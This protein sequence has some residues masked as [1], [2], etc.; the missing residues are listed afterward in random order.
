MGRAEQAAK[1]SDWLWELFGLR[2]GERLRL[3]DDHYGH[4]HEWNQ[5]G[6]EANILRLL[7]DEAAAAMDKTKPDAPST[8]VEH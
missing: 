4:P 1:I 3:P 8:A 5:R 6:V 2:K 7:Q